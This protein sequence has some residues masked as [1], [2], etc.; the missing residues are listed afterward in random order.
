MK[1]LFKSDAMYWIV[2]CLA[3]CLLLSGWSVA[4]KNLINGTT[5]VS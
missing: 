4:I 3:S 1:Y 2:V 5:V